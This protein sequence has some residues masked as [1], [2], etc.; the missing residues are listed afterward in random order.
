MDDELFV[1][2]LPEN[3]RFLLKLGLVN[4]VWVSM[5][6]YLAQSRAE[7]RNA[8]IREQTLASDRQIDRMLAFAGKESA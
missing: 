2:N 3:L 5:L 6:T 7:R 4:S 1:Q 8:R